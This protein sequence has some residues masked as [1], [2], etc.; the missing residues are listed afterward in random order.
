MWRKFLE[1]GAL[2]KRVREKE[3]ERERERRKKSIEI[4]GRKEGDKRVR[5]D[6]WGG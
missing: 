4:E 6:R 1:E 2:G 3:R 5:R